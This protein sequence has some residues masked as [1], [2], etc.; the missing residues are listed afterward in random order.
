MQDQFFEHSILYLSY[1]S[2]AKYQELL[3]MV[4]EVANGKK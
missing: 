4:E 3:D 1:L 2:Q